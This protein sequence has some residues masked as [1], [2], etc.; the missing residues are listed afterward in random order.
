MN[1][2][3]LKIEQYALNMSSHPGL[4]CAELEAETKNVEAM[5]EMLIGKLEASFLGLLIRAT[6]AKRILELGTFSG[7]SALA[8]AE[9]LPT[10]GEIHTI[11]IVRKDYTSRYWRESPHGIK[12]KSHLGAALEVIPNLTGR[13][14]MVF[15]DADK[16][17]YS[18]YFEL[19][20]PKLTARGLII[21]DNV[22]WSGR[23]LLD[24]EELV[25]DT[26]T[27]A[28]KKFNQM[29]CSRADLHKTMLPIRDG[30][31]LISKKVPS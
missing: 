5:P 17:N 24:D 16:E 4:Q 23:V 7:Y 9:H 28:I 6:G 8:M 31:L 22:L 15:I 14:D 26:A 18:N 30:I 13:F 19:V 27:L 11:D 10:D 25:S 12:I 21:V 2:T 29:V 3:D 20:V 1:F